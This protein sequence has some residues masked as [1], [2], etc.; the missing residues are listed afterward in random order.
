MRCGASLEALTADGWDVSLGDSISGQPGVVFVGKIGAHNLEARS[1]RWLA[2]L[3]AA[4]A[5]GASIVADYSD[6][7]LGLKTPLT[8][9]YRLL[10]PIV[11]AAIVPSDAMSELL[12]SVWHGTCITIPEAV[13]VPILP[14]HKREATAG[15]P[16]R[17][18]WFGHDSNIS[19]LNALCVSNEA[20]QHPDV[21]L[22]IV[23]N[24]AALESFKREVLQKGA[25]VRA[26]F[27]HWSPEGLVQAASLSDAC[28]IPSD[29]ADPRKRGAGANRLTAALALGLPTAAS[30]L[31]SYLSFLPYLVDIDSTEFDSFVINPSA[32]AGGVQAAQASVLQTYSALRVGRQWADL[33]STFQAKRLDTAAL[34]VF[35]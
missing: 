22:L 15:K 17:L 31:P 11:D 35:Q 1:N 19:Y 13:E 26:R 8:G 33:A 34:A 20:M 4:K 27:L 29:P 28:V 18:L 14:Y 6:H 9:F 12:Q 7:H 5:V 10:M 32:F 24:F 30:I 3:S 21:E 16:V 25:H 2:Q 23:S